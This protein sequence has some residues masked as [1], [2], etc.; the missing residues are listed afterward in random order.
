MSFKRL[1][2]ILAI[3]MVCYLE[4]VSSKAIR[5]DES[6]SEEGKQNKKKNFFFEQK[7]KLSII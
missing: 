3:F 1:A 4:N 7:L 5:Q 6:G 2:V